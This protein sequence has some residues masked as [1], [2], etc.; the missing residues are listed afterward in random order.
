MIEEFLR[1]INLNPHVKVDVKEAVGRISHQ[2]ALLRGQNKPV[3]K[4]QRKGLDIPY[5]WVIELVGERVAWSS[6][7]TFAMVT[8]FASEMNLSIKALC[9]RVKFKVWI[10]T[11]YRPQI[12]TCQH[13]VAHWR[14]VAASDARPADTRWFWTGT[15]FTV[16]RGT[17]WWRISLTC[18]N[19]SPAGDAD[20]LSLSVKAVFNPEGSE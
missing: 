11:V 8:S 19:R 7:W 13:E 4:R 1:I 12:H 16:C 5:V 20:A 15:A 9:H 17:C 14:P 10:L 2:G 6:S 3:D 18:S